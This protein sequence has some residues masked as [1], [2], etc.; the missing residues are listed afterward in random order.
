MKTVELRGTISKKGG[1]RFGLIC[2]GTGLVWGECTFVECR[3]PLTK[4]E[5]LELQPRHH[6]HARDDGEP[7][8]AD[9]LRARVKYRN[10]YAWVIKDA[11]VYETGFAYV[12][13]RGAIGWVD[14]TKSVAEHPRFRQ[15]SPP[16][17]SVADR[18]RKKGKTTRSF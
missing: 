3:G 7:D 4:D 2:S 8:T 6:V 5:L 14:L 17:K 1:T 16:R 9:E 18:P 10:C 12:H 11:V 15:R 13:P